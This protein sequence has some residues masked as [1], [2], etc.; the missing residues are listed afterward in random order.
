MKPFRFLPLAEKELQEAAQFYNE[1][2]SG[3]GDLLLAEFETVMARLGRHP[4]SGAMVSRRLRVARLND[5]RYS[6]I[7]KVEGEELIVVAV[8]H[9]SRKPGYWKGRA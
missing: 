8:A 3:F 7:Y 2:R 1:E 5:F 6:V 4:E 9:Q